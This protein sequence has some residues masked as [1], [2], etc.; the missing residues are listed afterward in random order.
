[1]NGLAILERDDTKISAHLFH[2]DPV[3]HTA[4]GLDLPADGSLERQPTPL[5]AEMGPLP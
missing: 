4:I 3:S 1:M 2:E 5:Q